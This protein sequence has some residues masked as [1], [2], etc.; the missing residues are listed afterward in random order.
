MIMLFVVSLCSVYSFA[1]GNV[2]VA[3]D[4]RTGS[5]HGFNDNY[6]ILR[7]TDIKLLQAEAILQSGDAT[8]DAF[9]PTMQPLRLTKQPSWIGL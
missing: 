8:V 1:Q 2:T 3:M 4:N 7:L 6:R 5:A 9:L